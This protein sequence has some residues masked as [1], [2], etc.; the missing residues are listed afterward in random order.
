VRTRSATAIAAGLA[1]SLWASAGCSTSNTAGAGGQPDAAP[2]DGGGCSDTQTDPR[3]CGTCGHDCEGGACQSG[4]CVTLAP[5]VLASGQHTPAGIAVDAT[6][7]YW[8]NRGTQSGAQILKCAKT[9]CKNTPTVLATG[10]WTEI[11][12]LAVDGMNVY[13]GASR[14]IFKCAIDGCHERPTV[15]WSGTGQPAGIAL[16]DASVYFDIPGQEQVNVCSI[17]GCDGATAVPLDP[18]ASSPFPPGFVA[19]PIAIAVDAENLYA[20]TRGP[21]GALL[22]CTRGT[23]SQTIHAVAIG[24]ASS[25]PLTFAPLL[26]VDAT[27][28]YLASLPATNGDQTP[29]STGGTGTSAGAHGAILFVA[30]DAFNN[31]PSTL[32]QLVSFP[33]AIATDGLSLYVADWGD[34]N[35]AGKR[36]SGVGRIATC[37]VAGCKD[38]AT[39]VQDY[40]SYPQGIA[41]D[42][43]H[44]Y[45]S[46]FGSGTDPSGSNDGRIM[47][48]AK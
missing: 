2:A 12:N 39:L 46:D 36:A 34:E 6:N 41:V 45:W 14:Q 7:V 20:V 10:S 17:D 9:G 24:V 32:I 33:S 13:W 3:N 38:I 47:V 8:V 23:C 31:V 18:G 28:V 40:V 22:A 42:D 11:T 4:A 16:D 44:V 26:A 48:R 5:G 35:D 19:S 15:V 21:P 43:A 29:A 1:S 30:K 37:P 25:E 27:N